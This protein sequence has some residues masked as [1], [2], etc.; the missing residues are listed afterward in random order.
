MTYTDRALLRRRRTGLMLRARE[1]SRAA[2]I[3]LATR[4]PTPP[5]SLLHVS[6]NRCRYTREY[7]FSSSWP[8]RCRLL[9]R[10]G[11]SLLVGRRNR[12]ALTDDIYFRRG[13]P[14]YDFGNSLV[15]VESSPRYCLLM[16][17]SPLVNLSFVG[18]RWRTGLET[19]SCRV[20]CMARACFSSC[21]NRPE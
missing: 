5:L 7:G 15:L 9:L 1:R 10:P 6:P 18:C 17:S 21:C 20:V 8:I 4:P 13:F 12:S 3:L 2:E 14:L 16:D 11:S 19:R